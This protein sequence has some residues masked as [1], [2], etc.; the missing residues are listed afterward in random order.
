MAQKEE[1]ST[2]VS[3]Y[4]CI[5][6]YFP[7]SLFLFTCIP[8]QFHIFTHAQMPIQCCSRYFFKAENKGGKREN[9]KVNKCIKHCAWSEVNNLFYCCAEWL[10]A[11]KIIIMKSEIANLYGF[12]QWLILDSYRYVHV[13]LFLINIEI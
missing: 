4:C 3:C 8:I 5:E 11:G 10:I 2:C 7:H 1:L 12:I 13:Y 6:L 9:R